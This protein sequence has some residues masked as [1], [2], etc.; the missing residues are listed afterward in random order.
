MSKMLFLFVNVLLFVTLN[1]VEFKRNCIEDSDCVCSDTETCIFEC[2]GDECRSTGNNADVKLVC[3]I[4]SD[5]TI[6]CSGDACSNIYI[7]AGN[8]KSLS[9]LIES[10]YGLNSPSEVLCPING[11][12]EITCDNKE[13]ACI[14]A[15]IDA[16]DSESLIVKTKKSECCYDMSIFCPNGDTPGP[17]I[18]GEQPC[19]II[20]YADNCWSSMTIYAVE[21]FYD[22][23]L[24]CVEAACLGVCRPEVKCTSNYRPGKRC[25]LD[26]ATECV[27]PDSEC[28]DHRSPSR[29]PTP[30]PI[31]NGPSTTPTVTPS[32]T[33]T[34]TPT[35]NPSTKPSQAP[36]IGT[37]APTTPSVSPTDFPTTKPT[38]NPTANPSTKPSVSP[39]DSPTVLPTQSPVPTPYPTGLTPAP[40]NGT[41]SPTDRTDDPTTNPTKSPNTRPTTK[42]PSKSPTN[43]P[44]PE[45]TSSPTPSP[46]PSPT[47]SPTPS[48]TPAP[49]KRPSVS[50]TLKPTSNPTLKPT[51]NPTPIPT[52]RP[53]PSPTKKPTSNPTKKPSNNPTKKPTSNPSKKPTKD[54][55]KIPTKYPTLFPTPWP[56]LRPTIRPTLP[57]TRYPTPYPTPWPTNPPTKH[58]TTQP[59][60]WP[61]KAPTKHPTPN[62]TKWPTPL[63]TRFPTNGCVYDPRICDLRCPRRRRAA[64]RIDYICPRR[65]L[66][67]INELE[68]NDADCCVNADEDVTLMSDAIDIIVYCKNID[69]L[70]EMCNKH[71]MVPITDNI[72]EKN[73]NSNSK[74]LRRQLVNIDTCVN[75][76]NGV[77]T[78]GTGND[79]GLFGIP[80]ETLGIIIGG[81]AGL[82][83]CL[84]LCICLFIGFCI[85]RRKEFIDS[86]RLPTSERV[87]SISNLSA[88][89]SQ[90]TD[91]MNNSVKGVTGE[92]ALP[93]PIPS[94]VPSQVSSNAQSHAQSPSNISMNDAGDGYDTT[95][96]NNNAM[97]DIDNIPLPKPD[98][99][100]GN[101]DQVHHINGIQ[102]ETIIPGKDEDTG[103]YTLEGNNIINDNDADMEDMYPPK[104]NN[105]YHTQE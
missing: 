45:P 56:T 22:F 17:Y 103:I 93:T 63:P 75:S 35:D 81:I 42:G 14:G 95:F 67:D 37:R 100:P 27:D 13:T 41:P 8:A 19:K 39:T 80:K 101:V 51:K 79:S 10:D 20:G 89:R 61:T 64:E 36:I 40:S 16:I 30:T 29:E 65:R 44:S 78:L 94:H 26:T 66:I 34:V 57:P 55:T 31:T 11:T 73:E 15:V 23:A 3:G 92:Y 52:D 60:K 59:T 46:T 24:T 87:T 70:K 48:P 98:L 85:K 86:L 21:S 43:N 28:T 83:C 47:E 25:F 32:D 88:T 62:P 97:V 82:I 1:A 96:P 33:P 71:D 68:Y 38:I 84:C 77:G 90:S 74:I 49:S 12:C 54:P 50:P 99:T 4:G 105:G 2:N 102:M 91:V 18:D 7:D 53:S 69:G 6:E 5:C 104:L 76:N 58:P 9:L 72:Y